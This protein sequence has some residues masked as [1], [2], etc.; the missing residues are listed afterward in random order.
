MGFRINTNIAALSAHASA[1]GN[2]RS[3]D[4]S[5]QKLNSGLRIS[6]AADDASGMAIADSLRS[7][8]SALGQAIM[9]GNDAIGIIQTA[10][11]AMDEQLKILDT[12]KV[13]ATQAAQD[14]QTMDS[15]KAL[16]ADIVRLMEELDNIATSTSFNGQN[17]LDG[18][19][20]NKEFQ[21]GAYSNQTAKANIGATTSNKIGNTRFETGAVIK[22]PQEDVQITFKKY[23]GVKDYIVE[24]TKIDS[25]NGTGIGF[26]AENINK[27]TGTT[28]IRAS[29]MTRVTGEDMV[30]AGVTDDSFTI[31]GVVI[32]RIDVK[33]K[34]E[35]GAL[36][37]AI[38]KVKDITG[39]EA[40]LKD[41]RLVLNS[42][43]GR[44]ID[45]TERT[46]LGDAVLGGSPS[47]VSFFSIATLQEA[48]A[49]LESLEASYPFNAKALSKL[50][51]PP[52][53][54]GTPSR[55]SLG[56]VPPNDPPGGDEAAKAVA[57]AADNN[58]SKANLYINGFAITG[59]AS[60]LDTAENWTINEN[61]KP[62][63]VVELINRRR[64]EHG[65]K[66][67]II[68]TEDGDRLKLINTGEAKDELGKV[69]KG[70]DIGTARRGERI[71]GHGENFAALHFSNAIGRMLGLRV[72]DKDGAEINE[73]TNEGKKQVEKLKSAHMYKDEPN[74]VLLRGPDAHVDAMEGGVLKANNYPGFFAITANVNAKVSFNLGVVITDDKGLEHNIESIYKYGEGAVDN[75]TLAIKAE[76]D[77]KETA[78]FGMA[79][80]IAA[81]KG[82]SEKERERAFAQLS[83]LGVS[84]GSVRNDGTPYGKDEEIPQNI[85]ARHD[86][87]LSISSNLG[88]KVRFKITAVD[89]TKTEADLAGEANIRPPVI[90]EPPRG[91][92]AD[93]ITLNATANGDAFGLGAARRI[94]VDRQRGRVSFESKNLTDIA[95]RTHET[96]AIY[97]KI[98]GDKSHVENYGRLTLSKQDGRDIQIEV[99]VRNKQGIERPDDGSALGMD[100][101]SVSE[102]TVAL[103]DI[104]G[105]IDAKQADAMGFYPSK[106]G[107]DGYGKSQSAGVTTLRGAMAVMDIAETAQKMLDAIRADLGSV[108]NQLVATVNN[109]SVTQVN[110]KFAESQ[111]RDVDFAA[112]SATFSKHN[113]LAQSGTYAMSQANAVQQN[114]LKL[115]Q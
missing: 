9:N 71:A 52:V 77:T 65:V 104:K 88:Y 47:V 19:F 86:T 6:S 95:G 54:E 42:V 49:P 90:T 103:R 72:S 82:L 43:D 60:G 108:Q 111:I 91:A 55:L 101:E 57:G 37:S 24:G 27:A 66:A 115:L 22:F 97:K 26:L 80:E 81:G 34:D 46:G 39:V 113:I 109:I 53:A 33:A 59:K 92:V 99:V 50:G 96:T 36:I 70:I 30:Q 106:K 67:E 11:K 89:Q 12:I 13:K 41:G 110:V 58:T 74:A 62:E 105:V 18:T 98:L 56:L 38:N 29:F 40:S 93:D 23:D 3:L 35:N 44:G 2:N 107:V 69:I 14:G 20:S 28:G 48:D 8:A 1:V 64:H 68:K 114:V 100:T 31:N 5:L 85:V 75:P 4:S 16:Q 73:A 76:A 112:E 21:I 32:G 51:I 7:Q 79:Y 83:M 78:N 10:D 61:T 63:T 15:R 25:K 87:N 102:A 84:I 17:L 94:S 45:I